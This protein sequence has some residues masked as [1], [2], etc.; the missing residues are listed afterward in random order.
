MKTKYYILQLLSLITFS[1][2]S[3]AEIAIR[4][5]I[6]HRL[7]SHIDGKKNTARLGG[8]SA[9]IAVLKAGEIDVQGTADILVGMSSENG[10][11]GDCGGLIICGKATIT[12]I[13]LDGY[14]TTLQMKDNVPLSNVQIDV[15]DATT[16]A[17]HN[18]SA[19]VDSST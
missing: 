10:N 1:T 7:Y 8:V 12:N 18:T 13:L 11:P 4:K 14:A 9:Y 3:N 19:Q 15:V 17:P 5:E 6:G 16:I 2:F